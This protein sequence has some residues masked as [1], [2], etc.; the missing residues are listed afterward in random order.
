VQRGGQGPSRER[1]RCTTSTTSGRRSPTSRRA[2]DLP[3]ALA[4]LRRVTGGRPPVPKT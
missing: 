2:G 1:S 4:A 3:A